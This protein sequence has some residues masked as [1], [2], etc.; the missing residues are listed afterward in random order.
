M[1]QWLCFL[2]D[3]VL[4][5]VQPEMALQ[6]DGEETQ[7]EES[8]VE[9]AATDSAATLPQRRGPYRK[10]M[11]IM[12]E[13]SVPRPVPAA[14]WGRY[15]PKMRYNCDQVP[16][17][18]DNSGRR[19]YIKAQSDVAVIT[20]QPGSEKRFGTLQVCLHAGGNTAQ[21]PLTIIFRGAKKENFAREKP[22]YHP[23][24]C[25]LFQ[26]NA[27]MDREQAVMW[28]EDIFV[29]FLQQK[30]PGDR[31]ILLLQDSMKAQRS[32]EY[33]RLLRNHGVEMAFGPRNQ[34]EYWQP[35]DAGHVGA[36]LKQL[37][38]VEFEKWMEQVS[39]PTEPE[40]NW[41]Y[42][43]NKW[44]NNKFSAKDKRILMTWVFGNAWGQLMSQKCPTHRCCVYF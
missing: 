21:P 37:G 20:G 29:P 18:L 34:T 3:V 27:W 11:R 30:H 41:V 24:V 38:R 22:L 23:D 33:V 35:I 43:W 31:D 1:R 5:P 40:S 2:R 26:S 25:V 8:V 13:H 44:E 7:P 9:A 42:N 4:K 6:S 15:P 10:K 28:A 16:F 12:P 19:T 32:G 17:N 39:N 14:D 36:V